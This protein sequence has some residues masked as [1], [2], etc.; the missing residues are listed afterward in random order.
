[1][2]RIVLLGADCEAAGHPDKCPGVVAGTV[3]DE[4]TDTSVS[5]NGTAVATRGDRM[6]FGPHEHAIDPA[7][8]S[9]VDTQSHLLQTDQT[10][11]VTVNGD[12]VMI[13]GDSTT[14]PGSGGLADVINSGGNKDVTVT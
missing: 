13:V 1:M 4:D 3:V 14:D 10:R 11:P 12:S 5:V 7:T 2:T 6:E 8:G 9:C